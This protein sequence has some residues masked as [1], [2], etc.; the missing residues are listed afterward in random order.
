MTPYISV[1][2][3]QMRPK[4]I[5]NDT[6]MRPKWDPN[7][8]RMILKW[9]LNETQWELGSCNVVYGLILRV[10]CNGNMVQLVLCFLSKQKQ[11]KKCMKSTH[12][13]IRATIAKK[14]TLIKVR[15]SHFK[16]TKSKRYQQTIIHAIHL[17][18]I[19]LSS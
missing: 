17:I 18:V 8:I 13:K 4:W 3:T 10:L 6:Q 11:G 9:D 15:I 5:A 7:E 14:C 16:I 19:C 1:I 2:I 12:C